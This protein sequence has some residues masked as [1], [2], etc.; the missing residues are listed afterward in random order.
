MLKWTCFTLTRRIVY[1]LRRVV[2]QVLIYWNEF[3]LFVYKSFK[4]IEE[5]IDLDIISWCK[6]QVHLKSFMFTFTFCLIR[7]ERSWSEIQHFISGTTLLTLQY[8]WTSG[9]E[10][11][12][13]C[14]VEEMIQISDCSK[15]LIQRNLPRSHT[16]CLNHWIDNQGKTWRTTRELITEEQ[17]ALTLLE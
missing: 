9:Q 4:D 16:T 14:L 1:W 7:V 17:G 11:T 6:R 8:N 2:I 5:G 10:C 3:G 13:Y 15:C 12:S